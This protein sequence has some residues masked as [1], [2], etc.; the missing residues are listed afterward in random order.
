MLDDGVEEEEEDNMEDLDLDLNE[1]GESTSTDCTTCDDMAVWAVNCWPMMDVDI[2]CA[3]CML[4]LLLLLVL[5][6]LV[7]EE[8]EDGIGLTT[9]LGLHFVQTLDMFSIVCLSASNQ[10][11]L[12]SLFDALS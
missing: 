1:F 2:C 11:D 9:S 10:L 12:L 4:L 6:M 3:C 8:D 5:L 7:M